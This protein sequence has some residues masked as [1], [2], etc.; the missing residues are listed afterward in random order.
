MRVLSEAPF[1]A[2]HDTVFSVEDDDCDDD[3]F[4]FRNVA[5]KSGVCGIV[6]D[7]VIGDELV[8]LGILLISPDLIELALLLVLLLLVLVLASVLLPLSWLLESVVGI[9][10]V[11]LLVNDGFEQSEDALDTDDLC[12]YNCGVWKGDEH[13][14]AL[15]SSPSCAR[16]LLLSCRDRFFVF[17]VLLCGLICDRAANGL[18]GC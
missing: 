4:E 1:S 15:V 14:N 18:E 12:L 16:S 6:G 8:K 2:L 9:V 11:S 17:R 10:R 3:S 13:E 7:D 5:V